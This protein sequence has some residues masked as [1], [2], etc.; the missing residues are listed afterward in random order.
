MGHFEKKILNIVPVLCESSSRTGVKLSYYKKYWR[1]TTLLNWLKTRK[2][3]KIYIIQWYVKKYCF[4]AHANQLLLNVSKL[5]N[6]A[7]PLFRRITLFTLNVRGKYPDLWTT[8]F[9]SRTIN[10]L[11]AICESVA[12]WCIFSIVFQIWNRKGYILRHV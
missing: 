3:Y 8:Y 11:P 12:M 4:E 1:S 7:T 10:K 2:T 6:Y 5:H 9:L